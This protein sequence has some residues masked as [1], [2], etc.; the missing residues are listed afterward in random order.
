[1]L[2]R[3]REG[4]SDWGCLMH[5]S[6]FVSTSVNLLMHKFDIETEWHK[7]PPTVN[8][9]R[10]S[11]A[12]LMLPATYLIMPSC[13]SDTDGEI[14]S[15]KSCAPV[16]VL[17]MNHVIM[18][19]FGSQLDTIWKNDQAEVSCLKIFIESTQHE[20]TYVLFIHGRVSFQLVQVSNYSAAKFLT[21]TLPILYLSSMFL[22]LKTQLPCHHLK[23]L[24]KP[25]R[26]PS[27]TFW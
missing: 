1:M 8:S 14:A 6:Q 19:E 5:T 17:P 2:T 10:S 15:H 26:G 20:Y 24:G 13:W 3:V 25:L 9:T 7:V 27:C 22:I 12:H 23:T 21:E 18:M 11:F 4:L 16:H